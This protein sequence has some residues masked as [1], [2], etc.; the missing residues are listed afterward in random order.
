MNKN[1]KKVILL[2]IFIAIL[3]FLMVV[4]LKEK[5]SEKINKNPIDICQGLSNRDTN[6]VS[7]DDLKNNITFDNRLMN[8]DGVYEVVDLPEFTDEEMD[9]LIS[10][11]SQ[12]SASRWGYAYKKFDISISPSHKESNIYVLIKA[13][14]DN[15]KQGDC[16]NVIVDEVTANVVDDYC[17]RDSSAVTEL[18]VRYYQDSDGKYLFDNPEL[19][20][21]HDYLSIPSD[22]ENCS[23]AL[24]EQNEVFLK[25][26]DEN[27]PS[28]ISWGISEWYLENERY[29]VYGS[30]RTSSKSQKIIGFKIY[31]FD[32]KIVFDGEE[33]VEWS[34]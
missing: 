33:V 29:V 9:G 7:L 30:A 2:I 14:F 8:Q 18:R 28:E 20:E 21:S 25:F 11:L 26:V 6:E 27:N 4:F 3:I 5:A 13:Y 23:M 34:Y 22:V 12:Y 16:V 32:S 19:V 15:K 10:I 24:L 17:K 31:P 1:I